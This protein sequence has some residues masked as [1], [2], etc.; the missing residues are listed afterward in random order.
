MKQQIRLPGIIGGLGPA[1]H[2][3]FERRLLAE[4][5]R[6]GGRSDQDCPEWV[7]WSA[8]GVPERTSALLA[9]DTRVTVERIAEAA[10]R[11]VAAG[12]DF[13]AV[14]CNTA[15]ALRDEVMALVPLP[16]L[17][18][19]DVTTE[20]LAR[21]FERGS[22]VLVLATTGTLQTGLYRKRLREAGF[23]PVEFE[24]DSPEQTDVMRAIYDD[25]FGIKST[26]TAVDE[27]AVA[28]AK[29]ALTKTPG[30]VCAIA[31]CTELSVAF[32][33]VSNPPLPLIDPLDALAVATYDVAAGKRPLPRLV[34]SAVR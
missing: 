21:R 5:A 17:D 18:L 8:T 24:V 31:G 23:E 29:E 20:E 13:A 14:P 4:S 16:W 25:D 6:R 33:T 9:N 26:G 30:T 10:R 1:A 34:A 12:A 2:I 15:H 22:R 28:L 3:E 7:L 27:R 32:A 11:L 19:I